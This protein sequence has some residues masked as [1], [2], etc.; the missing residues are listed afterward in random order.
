MSQHLAKTDASRGPHA[1]AGPVLLLSTGGGIGGEE[2]FTTNLAEALV[3]RGW[4]VRVAALG[5]AHVEELMRRGLRVERLPI[6]GRGPLGLFRGAKALSRYANGEG[7][8]ILH[9]Q[10][11]GPALMCILARTLGMFRA[12]CP[13][14]LGHNHGIRRYWALS[15][16]FNLL[17]LSIACSDFERT[18]LLS[19]GLWEEKVVRVHNGVDVDK[20]DVSDAERARRRGKIRAEFGLDDTVPVAGFV[21]RLSPEKAPDDFVAS[22]DVARQRVPDV[23]Y[24]VVGD[25]PM[26]PRLEAMR[27]ELR[28]EDRIILTGFRRDVPDLLCAIDVLALVSHVET[29]SLTT[30][31]AMALGLPCVVTDVGGNPEQVTEGQ[32]GSVVPDARP[33]EIARALAELLND[34]ARRRSYGEAA[35]ERVRSYLNRDRMVEEIEAIYR[36]HIPPAESPSGHSGR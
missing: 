35:H 16:I 20:L 8:R 14:L 3:R 36:K 4:D 31:E 6:G 11:A 25:G 13:A 1:S 33:D 15:K 9:S 22:F 12:P 19:F 18:K 28:A 17:D 29:F 24:L 32:N 2:S 10:S 23:R 34:P 27:R 26:R 30:L 5:P 7:V 21:G